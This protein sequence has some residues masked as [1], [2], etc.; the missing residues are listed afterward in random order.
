MEGTRGAEMAKM[1]PPPSGTHSLAQME[2]D[3]GTTLGVSLSPLV[4]FT[5]GRVLL[6]KQKPTSGPELLERLPSV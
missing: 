3:S 5:A 6:L 2:R 1:L 4:V